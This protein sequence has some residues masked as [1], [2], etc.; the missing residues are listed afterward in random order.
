MTY[1]WKQLKSNSST[2]YKALGDSYEAQRQLILKDQKFH[3]LPQVNEW[4]KEQQQ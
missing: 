2:K 3:D 1:I 4:K